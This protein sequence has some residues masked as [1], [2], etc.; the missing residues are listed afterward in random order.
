MKKIISNK[1]V[2]Y[3]KALCA[4]A[5]AVSSVAPL[6]CRGAWHQPKE[7]DNFESFLQKKHN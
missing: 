1:L 6:C 7:P 3:G 4:I 5:V 2:K